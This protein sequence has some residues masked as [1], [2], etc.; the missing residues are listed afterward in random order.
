MSSAHSQWNAY[1]G[2]HFFPSATRACSR[3]TS[4]PTHTHEEDQK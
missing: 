3:T 4:Q 1:R 2:F